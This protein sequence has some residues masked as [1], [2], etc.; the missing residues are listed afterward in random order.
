MKNFLLSTACIAIIASQISAY[1]L[2]KQC[3]AAWS[4]NS[5]GYSGNRTVCLSGCLVS[6][7]AMALNDCQVLLPLGPNKDPNAA[8]PG[9]L[10]TW[11]KENDGFE[12]GYGFKWNATDSL[13]LIW[14]KFSVNVTELE[15]SF[16][17]GKKIFLH[18]R[19]NNHYVLMTGFNRGT[20][21]ADAVFYVNDPNYNFNYYPQ[22][23][24][25]KGVATSIFRVDPNLKCQT[26]ISNE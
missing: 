10:N 16:M 21:P 18:V 9:T 24:V 26:K 14:E 1:P 20:G 11:L 17:A 12:E 6:S 22:S 8:N 2:F 13:G 19:N 23:E 15:E 25:T 5:L 7:V 3:D 4:P